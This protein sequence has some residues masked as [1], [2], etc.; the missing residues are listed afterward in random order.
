MQAL[1]YINQ[2]KGI[3][4]HIDKY[5]RGYRWGKREIF[6]LLEDIYSFKKSSNNSFYCLQP[7]V[8]SKKED[9]NYELID[10]QQRSTTIYLILKYLLNEDFYTLK[11]ETR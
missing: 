2:L 11:Y 6:S 8:V 9:N 7:L 5:Q 10:G 1:K 4:F 3:V